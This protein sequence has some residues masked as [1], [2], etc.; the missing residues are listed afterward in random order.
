MHAKYRHALPQLGDELFL[1]DGGLETTLIFHQGLELPHFAAFDLVRDRG[2]PGGAGALLRA[3]CRGRAARRP[4]PCPRDRDLAVRTRTGAAKLG[5][6][7]EAL[8]A[9]NVRAVELAAGDPRR[10]TRQ[11][12]TP[13]VICGV[14]GP[15]GDGYA[16]DSF[17]TADEAEAYHAAQVA[18]F[19]RARRRL[20]RRDHHDL[21]RRGDRHRPGGARG[22]HAGLR[23]L[24]RRDR[25]AAAL[26]HGSRRGDRRL[27]RG[28][29]RLS[30]LL[31]DQLRPPVAFPRPS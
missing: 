23:L 25:R 1:T 12:G 28:D 3:L 17:M 10:P 20:H 9:V 16:P 13:I 27:R 8:D 6:S 15:G 11:P 4:R 29:G 19:A 24:H 30:R 2:G 21:S 18:S 31:H 22:G 14:I 5:Y 7:A 26:G